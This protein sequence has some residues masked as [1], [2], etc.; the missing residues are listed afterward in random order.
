MKD[1]LF[2]YLVANDELDNFLGYEPKCPNCGNK[3]IKIE[4][5]MCL[6]EEWEEAEK[7]SI[8]LG[9]CCVEDIEYHCNTCG[10]GYSKD[11]KTYIDQENQIKDD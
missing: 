7:G 6:P 4:Y 11:L 5:G 2:N 9:G 8:Y 3:M 1:D 10:R